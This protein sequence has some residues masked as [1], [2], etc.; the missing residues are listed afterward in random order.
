MRLFA[1]MLVAL[2]WSCSST[3]KLGP[4]PERSVREVLEALEKRNVDFRHFHGKLSTSFESPD[5]G[6]SG[7]MTVRMVRDSAIFVAV[8]KFGIEAAR[9]YAD[10]QGYTVLYRFEAAYETGSMSQIN[11]LI[12]I[13]ADFYDMQQLI[14]GNVV[15]PDVQPTMTKDSVWYVV[16][17]STDGLAVRYFVNGYDLS[18]ARMEITDAAGRKASLDFEDYR[19]IAGY[20]RVAFDRKATFPYSPEGDATLKMNFSEFEINVPRQIQFSIPDNYEK[21]N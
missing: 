1:L 14:F 4:V 8:R 2:L 9:M 20:G 10:P 17:G 21:I 5:E 13:N 12:G 18:L 3:K 16:S 7:S 11:K 15:L 19:D 6:V